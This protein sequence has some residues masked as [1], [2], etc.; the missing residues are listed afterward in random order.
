[1]VACGGTETNTVT[2]PGFSGSEEPPQPPSAV[3]QSISSGRPREAECRRIERDGERDICLRAVRRVWLPPSVAFTDGV[4]RGFGDAGAI[5]FWDLDAD[6]LALTLRG[7]HAV[8]R[9]IDEGR[10]RRTAANPAFCP[11][12]FMKIYPNCLLSASRSPKIFAVGALLAMSVFSLAL[13][14]SNPLLAQNEAGDSP[15]AAS[16]GGGTADDQTKADAAEKDLLDRL[17]YAYGVVMSRQL[18]DQGVDLNLEKFTAAFK[19]SVAGEELAMSDEDLRNT[20]RE[21]GEMMKAKEEEAGNTFLKDNAARDGVTVTASGLQY[22]VLAKGDG[23]KPKATDT[24]KV[25]YEGTLTDGT[26]FDSSYDR[27]EPISFPLN[28]VIRGWTEG[29]QL[30]PVGSKFRFVIPYDLAYGERGSPP[31]IPP[32]ATLVFVVELLGIE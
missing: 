3:R 1:M 19:A 12:L 6:W 31:T 13:L 27:G 28:G 15:A 11:S 14:L 7:E 4:A 8:C 29:V 20:F 26:K 23:P 25:H 2:F 16:D 24:V 5:A 10:G 17:S 32:K 18:M 22:E 9:W 30:M 21:H